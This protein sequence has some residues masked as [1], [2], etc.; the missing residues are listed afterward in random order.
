[1]VKDI[2][3]WSGK[4]YLAYSYIA[5]FIVRQSFPQWSWK[6]YLTYISYFIVRESVANAEIRLEIPT[7]LNFYPLLP[8]TVF[9]FMYGV[10]FFLFLNFVYGWKVSMASPLRDVC[11]GCNCIRNHSS[12]LDK[13]C[14]CTSFCDI[15]WCFVMSD[16]IEDAGNLDFE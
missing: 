14:F 8:N 2:T 10:F 6:S 1:M 3:Q 12:S 15:V 11:L 13:Y 7:V 5:Y 9:G 16:N 4:S